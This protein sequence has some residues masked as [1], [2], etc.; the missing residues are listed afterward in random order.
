MIRPAIRILPAAAAA[1]VLAACG[2]G[3][4][5]DG[6][7]D[8][9]TV[10]QTY[11]DIQ[12]LLQEIADRSDTLLATGGHGHAT[13]Q[14]AGQT[15][16]ETL[17]EYVDCTGTVC[18]DSDGGTITIDDFINPEGIEELE[19]IVGS[20]GAFNTV[21]LQGGLGGILDDEEVEE[22]LDEFGVSLNDDISATVYGLWG[23][24]GVAATGVIDGSF[25]G[26][27]LGL[28]VSGDFQST[29][30]FTYGDAAGTNPSGLGSATWSGVAE[31]V[32]ISTFVRR[33]GTATVTIADLAAPTVGVDIDIAGFEISS[34]HWE[35]MPLVNGR[36]VNG[37]ESN[38]YME[39]N[40]HGSDHSEAYG[41]FDTGAHVGAFGAKRE[42]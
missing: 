21:T 15:L 28:D 20:R 17:A 13:F 9:P 34:S 24:H 12:P 27:I 2:G 30:A 42:P 3:G 16:D 38:D 11:A 29:T 5:D 10:R 4:D 31:A 23:E 19:A 35:N 36:F 40:F 41:V 26:Q 14:G 6:E 8:S 37:D 7:G 39:G 1:L 25:T 18:V 22:F 32:A 33:Q